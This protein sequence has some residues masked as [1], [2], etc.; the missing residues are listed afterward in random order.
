MSSK[1]TVEKSAFAESLAIVVRAVASV[2]HLPVLANVLIESEGGQLRLAATD[3]TLGVAVWMDARLDGQIA[4]TL[5]AKTLTD[6]VNS[7]GDSEVQFSVNGK[8]EAA[9]KSGTFKGVVRGIEASEF[10]AIPEYDLANAIIL[11]AS[12][13]KE[14]IQA[15][16]FAA[17]TDQARPVL[18]G[19]QLSLN[20]NTLAM[21][22]TDGFRLAV[23]KAA[24]PVSV[25]SQQVII[26][27]ASLKETVRV[28][29]A[30]KPD[31][32]HLLVP[33]KG[34]QV[35]LRAGNVQLISQL[36]DGRFPDYQMIVPKSYKTR[37][38]LGTADL[39]KACKQAAV[40]AREGGNVIQLR[41]TPGEEQTGKVTVLAESG[42]TGE[43]EVELPAT[44]TGPEMTIA[45][46]VKFL[47][48][49]LEAIRTKNVVIETNTHN[50][51]A[52]IRPAG[53]EEYLYILMPMHVDGK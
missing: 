41:L 21:A 33:Q 27:A 42:D 47:Q 40:I 30:T 8:P 28:L 16:A 3:L 29:S 45:F 48:D 46:N 15:T 34:S 22:A 7:L 49:G 10:P 23:K 13:L 18:E 52:V 19:V 4:L 44:I 2:P 26:P 51:P 36:I 53:E 5:P 50:T 17:S 38:V 6:I 20:G 32:V 25:S 1:V 43:S 37:T 35:V 12:L 14:M 24:L 11:E 39:L 31:Q 9:I